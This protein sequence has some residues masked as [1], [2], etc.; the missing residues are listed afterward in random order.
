MSNPKAYV[1]ETCEVLVPIARNHTVA[2]LAEA[3]HYAQDTANAKCREAGCTATDVTLIARRPWPHSPE[4][5]L[6]VYHATATEGR[7]DQ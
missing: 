1:G 6:L 7:N 5:E 4:L 2:M 3:Q